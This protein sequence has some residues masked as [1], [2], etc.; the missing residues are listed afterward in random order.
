ME[1][2]WIR[3]G[4]RL[5]QEKHNEHETKRRERGVGGRGGQSAEEE[6]IKRV[7]QRITTVGKEGI[8]REERRVDG[9]GQVGMGW[10]AW[11]EKMAASSPPFNLQGC[12]AWVG[13]RGHRLGL[14]GSRVQV[15]NF[16]EEGGSFILYTYFFLIYFF[17][18]KKGWEKKKKI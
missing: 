18:K 10:V 4:L 12:G 14:A 8:G 9:T 13:L 11:R 3:V 2:S 6:E 5:D 7:S 17:I 16:V 1:E 15:Y